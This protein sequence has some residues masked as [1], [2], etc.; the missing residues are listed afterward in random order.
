MYIASVFICFLIFSFTSLKYSF[1]FP[2]FPILAFPFECHTTYFQLGSKPSYETLQWQ[3]QFLVSL[4]YSKTGI[5]QLP[6]PHTDLR[7]YNCEKSNIKIAH[8]NNSIFALNDA[9]ERYCLSFSQ[10]IAERWYDNIL[11]MATVMLSS[12]VNQ[13]AMTI[14]SN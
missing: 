5:Q 1:R 13:A 4:L 14:W 6:M 12:D 7:G 10:S 2:F 3:W 9:R 11:G 8:V